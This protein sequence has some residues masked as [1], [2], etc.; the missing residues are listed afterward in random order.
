MSVANGNTGCG[1]AAAIKPL[2]LQFDICEPFFDLF[3]QMTISFHFKWL[4][5]EWT[6]AVNGH[7]FLHTLE[8]RVVMT[9]GKTNAIIKK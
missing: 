8:A 3:T 7:P 5:I 1:A 6:R 2:A 4:N 9:S